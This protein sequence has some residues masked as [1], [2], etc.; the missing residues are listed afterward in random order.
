MEESNH[1]IS[2][3]LEEE[4]DRTSKYGESEKKKSRTHY[5]KRKI[6]HMK[7]KHENFEH[8]LFLSN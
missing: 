4:K 1:T 8:D 5:K 3:I 2:H 7:G 6:K